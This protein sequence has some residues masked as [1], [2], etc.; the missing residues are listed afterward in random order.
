MRTH[1]LTY[2]GGEDKQIRFSYYH[3]ESVDRFER[4]S[5][6]SIVISIYKSTQGEIKEHRMQ[7]L[8]KEGATELETVFLDLSV[9]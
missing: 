2:R 5:D 6:Q 3:D 9:P 4:I 1:T 8:C 7:N